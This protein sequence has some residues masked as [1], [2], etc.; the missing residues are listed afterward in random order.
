MSYEQKDNSG[1]LFKNNRREKETHPH[2][3]GKA[4]IGGVM[5]WVSAWTKE[6]KNGRFQSLAFT[7]CE[8]QPDLPRDSDGVPGEV[9]PSSG[10][11]QQY[12]RPTKSAPVDP[13]GDDE[14][15]KDDDIPF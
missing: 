4:M 9:I 7:R 1:T 10:P 3:K 13:F 12:P 15:F 14:Q 11:R 2:A 8:Q 6:G 5:Y